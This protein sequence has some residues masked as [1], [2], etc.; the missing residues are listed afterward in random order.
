MGGLSRKSAY[1]D[2]LRNN[3]IDPIIIDAG[4]A[5]FGRIKYP[6]VKLPIEQFKA[7]SFLQAME[8]IGC[9]AFNIGE[10]DLAGGYDFLKELKENSTI[11]FI[12]ANLFSVE[13]GKPAFDPYVIVNRNGLKVG[14][15]GVSDNLSSD[16]KELYKLDYI[17]EGQKYID[18]IVDDVDVLIMLVNGML[19]NRNVILD[20]FKKADYIFLSRSVMNTR[21][22]A[23]QEEGLPIFYTIGLDGKY[24]IDIS[25]TISDELEPILD[26]SAYEYRIES[27]ARN[28]INLKKTEDGQ[29]L[30]EKYANNPAIIDQIKNYEKQVKELEKKIISV[31]NPSKCKVVPLPEKMDYDRDMQK[32]IDDV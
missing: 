16:I 30:E 6:I 14:I 21:T 29:S 25:T 9:D 20:S 19:N 31:A 1:L 12:S 22:S 5:L 10:Y 11:P 18:E 3:D 7:Q 24:L 15:I 27:Y 17:K 23:L 13:T 8:K 32:F 4:D 2:N 26:V 28:L